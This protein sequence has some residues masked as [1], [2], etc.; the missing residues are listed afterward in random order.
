M[1]EKM[2]Q[3]TNRGVIQS[4]HAIRSVTITRSHAFILKCPMLSIIFMVPPKNKN[5]SEHKMQR[6][7][8]QAQRYAKKFFRNFTLNFMQLFGLKKSIKIK[9]FNSHVSRFCLIG[10][11][12]CG[13]EKCISTSSM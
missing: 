2:Y 5:L 13:S 10:S 8:T 3:A 12:D 1:T 9:C 7:Y 6:K 4:G 11:H